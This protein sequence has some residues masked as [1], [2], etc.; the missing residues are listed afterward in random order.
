MDGH[1]ENW[2][3]YSSAFVSR[4][5]VSRTHEAYSLQITENS[6]YSGRELETSLIFA[7]EIAQ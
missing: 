6:V 2:K 7:R 3:K 5:F 1:R 4:A